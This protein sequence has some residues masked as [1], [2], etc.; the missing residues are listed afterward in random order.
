M[1]RKPD[2]SRKAANPPVARAFMSEENP[3]QDAFDA[4]TEAD[5]GGW[6]RKARESQSLSIDAVA[7]A[8]HLDVAIVDALEREAFDELGATVFAK[9]HL[10]A[11]ASYLGLDERQAA[12]RF[13]AVSG[14]GDDDLPELIVQYNKPLRAPS[15]LPVIAGLV[16]AAIIV[17]AG[18]LYAG[19]QLARGSAQPSEPP[20]RRVATD[21]ASGES[22]T[23]DGEQPPTPGN[24][25]EPAA[26]S[27]A[28]KLAQ[29][30]SAPAATASVPAQTATPTVAQSQTATPAR[31]AASDG[32]RLRFDDECWFEVRDADDR[33]IAYGTARAGT[34]R[35]ITGRRPFAVTL[36]VADA[37]T[38]TVDGEPFALSATMRRGRA[39][40][41]AVP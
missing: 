1:H 41:F 12:A 7:D 33:R 18:L 3:Q 27:F 13:Q 14:I 38:V 21:V 5:V 32:L 6:L 39:A 30:G 26:S 19:M 24:S 31:S 9:G 22:A 23:L 16:V 40:K 28:E 17:A 37:V 29:A 35:V 20:V 4:A 25:T 8:L 15:R 36:G 10:R 34:E 2:R 11:V